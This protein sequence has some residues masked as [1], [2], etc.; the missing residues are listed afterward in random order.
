MFISLIFL[1]Y[2]PSISKF[3]NTRSLL[4]FLFILGFYFSLNI[5]RF[6]RFKTFFFYSGLFRHL[7]LNFG[8]TIGIYLTAS[9]YST[10]LRITVLS[11]TSYRLQD[12]CPVSLHRYSQPVL[13]LISFTFFLNYYLIKVLS[14][15]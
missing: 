8:V 9:S 2:L 4:L 15:E 11:A 12:I 3:P 7:L 14:S 6:Q 5:M 13:Y 1:M 10:D